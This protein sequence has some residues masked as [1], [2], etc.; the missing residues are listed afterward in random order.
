MRYLGAA[1]KQTSAVTSKHFADWTALKEELAGL[2]K[3]LLG[4]PIRQ[5]LDESSPPSIS[6]R[7]QRIS[8]GHWDTRQ[9]PTQ[10]YQDNL[11]IAA[12]DFTEF[13]G[14]LDDYFQELE[15]YEDNL[16]AAGAPYTKG[17]AFE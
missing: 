11:E 12:Q 10:T 15:K 14:T 2:R 9:L 1:L 4:D 6:S 3:Q 8:Y 5:S 7:V 13:S 17:R 16:E